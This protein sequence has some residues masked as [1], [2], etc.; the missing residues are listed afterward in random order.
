MNFTD[1][2]ELRK[3]AM[4][5]RYGLWRF[6]MFGTTSDI[7]SKVLVTIERIQNDDSE[8]DAHQARLDF[9]REFP[10]RD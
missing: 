4:K 8:F 2:K 3:H 6:F 7:R 9:V 1:A 10:I 5:S